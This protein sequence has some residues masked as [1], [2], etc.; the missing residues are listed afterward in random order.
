M[1]LVIVGDSMTTFLEK[2]AAGI[3]VR[4]AAWQTPRGK[5]DIPENWKK[6]KV[7]LDDNSVYILDAEFVAEHPPQ[8]VAACK[9]PDTVHKEIS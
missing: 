4:K 5:P 9:T 3:F 1:L 8:W 2:Q 6:L 7:W